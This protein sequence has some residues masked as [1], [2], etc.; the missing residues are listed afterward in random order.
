M[1]Q[2]HYIPDAQESEAVL[3]ASVLVEGNGHFSRLRELVGPGYWGSIAHKAVFHAMRDCADAGDPLDAVSVRNRLLRG[4]TITPEEV[5]RVL[6]EELPN[7]LACPIEAVDY[8]AR[9]VLDAWRRREDRRD[10]GELMRLTSNG[11]YDVGAVA[12]IAD[13]MKARAAGNM[14]AAGGPILTTLADVEPRSIDWLWAGR[15]P[16]GRLSLLVGRPGEGKSFLSLAMAAAVT[17]GTPWPD[18]A[19]CPSGSV[20]VISAEDD[21]ADTLRPRLDAH[22]GN[23]ERVHLLNA[24]R[25][26]T[27]DGDREVMFALQD[28]D[29]LAAALQR[30]PDCK[31]VV[32]DP[33]GSFLGGRTDAHRDNE[34]RSVLAPVG[35]LAEEYGAAVLIVAHRRKSAGTFA[36][37]L[38]LGSR[39]FTGICR[40][41]WH[42]SRD[43]EN[44][45]RR[46]LLPGKNNLA[47]EGDGLAFTIGGDRP[48]LWWEREPVSMDAD[49][50]LAAEYAARETKPGPEPEARNA[51]VEWLAAVLSPGRVATAEVK[52]EAKAAGLAWRT[53]QR[54]AD[55][56]GVIREKPSFGGGWAWRLP[57]DEE[58]AKSTCQVPQGENNLASWRLRE[59]TGETGDSEPGTPEDAKLPVLGENVASSGADAGPEP[60][61]PAPELSHADREIARFLADARPT[62]DGGWEVPNGGGN[63]R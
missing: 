22:H 29:A 56:L 8:H 42:L 53:I 25:V 58:D 41:V 9:Q 45:A 24:V 44:A 32:V 35:R 31:L 52:S 63:G 36:D 38:A 19:V 33:I 27:K 12:A 23:P 43:P 10:A 60:D 20:I 47:P 61:A 30:H 17:T 11:T 21:P 13:R 34:V 39:A 50:G 18:G 46:L 5:Q 7:V 16:L 1:N 15:F 51:A 4:D 59:N 37:D 55:E 2:R 6:V 62:A 14:R 48:R 26:R 57:D 54:A 40:V 3:L 49:A 28:V